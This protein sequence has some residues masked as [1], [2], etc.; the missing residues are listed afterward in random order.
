VQEDGADDD[1]SYYAE[2]QNA[3]CDPPRPPA[4]KERVIGRVVLSPVGLYV[5]CRVSPP[6]GVASAAISSLPSPFK[7]MIL[8]VTSDAPNAWHRL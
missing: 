6:P 5:A 3:Y 1:Y 2:E 8:S 4:G 7:S